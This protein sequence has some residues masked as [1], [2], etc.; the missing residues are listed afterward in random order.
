VQRL[1]LDKGFLGIY[2]RLQIISFDLIWASSSGYS[3]HIS[4]E[5]MPKAAG[6]LWAKDT[7]VEKTAF[8]SSA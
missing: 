3:Q 6:V 4:Q 7:K 8:L 1:F 2:H 5:K